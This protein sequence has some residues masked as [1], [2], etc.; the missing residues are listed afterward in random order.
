MKKF[1]AIVLA[2]MMLISLGIYFFGVPTL[3]AAYPAYDALSKKT[4]KAGK[5]KMWIKL[6]LTGLGLF[7]VASILA[8]IIIRKILKV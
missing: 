1:L 2:A 4:D 6:G 5:V 7:C 3:A 8:Y